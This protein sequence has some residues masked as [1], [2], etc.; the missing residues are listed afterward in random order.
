MR[1]SLL[2]C[3]IVCFSVSLLSAYSIGDTVSDISWSDT[4]GGP[5]VARTLHGLTSAN[6][7][8]LL[9]FSA[10][11][12]GPCVS[13]TPLLQE[14]W[15]AIGDDHFHLVQTLSDVHT[16]D[17][18]NGTIW[19][20]RFNPP[21]TYWLSIS[22]ELS[23]HYWTFGNGYI[24]YYVVIDN[25]NIMRHSSTTRPTQQFIENLIS[26]I[27][28]DGPDAMVNGQ[29]ITFS[30]E[31]P[32]PGDTVN[33]SATVHNIGNQNI[34]SADV[35]FYYSLE[36]GVDLQMIST[37]SLAGL[38][39]GESVNI[40]TVWN[41]DNSLEPTYYVITVVVD[42]VLP[43]DVNDN[44]NSAHTNLPMP[45]E[46]AIFQA[47]G[48][49]NTVMIEWVTLSE[50]DNLGFNLYRTQASKLPSFLEAIPVKLNI[51]LIPGQ[52]TSSSPMIYSFTDRLQNIGD[53]IYILETVS[54]YGETEEFQTRVH[55]IF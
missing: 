5:P 13:G 55:W 20:Y 52:G 15:E 18:V 40:D 7:I 46:L 48:V 16:W 53:Y 29:E 2:F 12:C 1:K 30:P 11:W 28:V 39:P 33:I 49:A 50:T 10:T 45:V 22:S 31:N 47:R 24:P 42:N 3:F 44:N 4:D 38:S 27:Q 26:D 41:T 14:M 8:V 54:V 51:D 37:E 19:R 43:F 34:T 21:L 9:V 23:T 35:K 32:M 17:N 25:D 36:P 6:K